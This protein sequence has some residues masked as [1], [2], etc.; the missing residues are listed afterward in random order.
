MVLKTYKDEDADNDSSN[1]EI[2]NIAI[3]NP[4]PPTAATDGAALIATITTDTSARTPDSETKPL[5][6]VKEEHDV[7]EDISNNKD[8][9]PPLKKQKQVSHLP[10]NAKLSPDVAMTPTTAQP[11]AKRMTTKSKKGNNLLMKST[12]RKG[13]KKSQNNKH[14][15]QT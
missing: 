6:D 7:S 14:N 3:T 15:T 5:I 10:K 13:K 11:K 4:T 9:N 12:S 8:Q 1:N 2:N